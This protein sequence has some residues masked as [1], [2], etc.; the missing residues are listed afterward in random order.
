MSRKKIISHDAILDAAEAV[1]A[2]LGAHRLS[3]NLVAE[4][5]GISK[6]GL[7]YSF[8]TREALLNAL[9]DRE[10]VRYKAVV[11]AARGDGS[12]PRSLLLAQLHA[13]RVATAAVDARTFS[14]M[15]AMTQ[16]G[17]QLDAYREQY[18]QYFRAL[19]NPSDPRAT[20]L[21]LATE[22]MFMLRGSGLM[23]WS[24]EEW[25]AL[26]DMVQEVCLPEANSPPHE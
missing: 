7:T 16:S 26:V 15:A 5:A 19:Q 9:T 10:L 22:A 14:I 3:L 2:E 18:S 25:Q 11:D 24:A 20:V 13:M 1:V 21:M 12:D 8:P 6:G 17:A 4:R 23:Q